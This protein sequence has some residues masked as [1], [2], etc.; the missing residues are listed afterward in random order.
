MSNQFQLLVGPEAFV[1][2]LQQDLPQCTNNFYAQF[3]TF[4]GDD[5]GKAFADLLLERSKAGIDVRL[6]VDYYS[7]AV[8]SDTYPILIH[9]RQAVNQERQ[10]TLRLFDELQ[11]QGIQVKRTAPMGP[12]WIYALYRDHKK[13]I[14]LDE[15]VAYVGGI[16][17]SDHNYAWHDY[18]VR[19]QGPLVQDLKCDFGSSWDGKT[20]AFDTPSVNEASD[21]ILNQC[22]GR[23]SIFE[24]ILAMIERAEEEIIIESPYLLGDRIESTILR[25]AERGVKV[26]LIIPY[27]SNK[28]VYR[29]WIRA[30]LQRLYHPNITYF[31]YRG[32]HNMTHAKMVIVDRRWVS[33]GSFNM[34]EL[35]GLTQKEL[36]V[37]SG[38]PDL[39]SQLVTFAEA[40]IAESTPLSIPRYS[41]GRFT[42]TLAYRFFR[43]WTGRLVRNPKWKTR[44]C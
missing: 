28:F 32:L 33:F 25:A 4:E 29:I 7:D 38:N 5:S 8:L 9:R 24:E 30:S 3:S 19:I 15:D 41:F 10:Q 34:F 44:Y 35:E 2:S 36:N 40:D 31:G 12:F 14:I 23:Y 20:L 1:Q 37:F 22:A 43:W 26:R 39:I 17:I 42:Y 21:F 11:K 13:M 18:M 27:H 16:N 6:V